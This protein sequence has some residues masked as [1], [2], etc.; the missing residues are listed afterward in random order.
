MYKK[1]LMKKTIILL[2]IQLLAVS[3]FASENILSR[4]S[5]RCQSADGSLTLNYF[6][7]MYQDNEAYATFS[8]TLKDPHTKMPYEASFLSKLKNV[9]KAPSAKETLAQF[10]TELN[11]KLTLKL[12]GE[13]VVAEWIDNGA[14]Q[15]VELKCQGLHVP[16]VSP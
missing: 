5:M 10:E 1:G 2:A 7:R 14:Q 4:Q 13:N 9:S 11:Q 6:I 3:S 16:T 15:P 8:Q 12:N